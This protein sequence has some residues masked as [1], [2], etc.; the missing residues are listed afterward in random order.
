MKSLYNYTVVISPDDNNTFFAYIPAIKSCHAW[1][2]SADEAWKELAF[3][4]DMI[5]EEYEEEGRSLPE[6]VEL[7]VA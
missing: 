3:V 2:E 1:G 7:V 5:K 6:N 4:F